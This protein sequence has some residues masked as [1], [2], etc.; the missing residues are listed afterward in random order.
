MKDQLSQIDRL[1]SSNAPGQDS[2]M[3]L[4]AEEYQQ[5]TSITGKE[6]I[7]I[8]L[9]SR[10]VFSEELR[11]FISN[12]DVPVGSFPHRLGKRQAEL[13]VYSG[14]EN[15]ELNKQVI[16]DEFIILTSFCP[17]F[18][19]VCTSAPRSQIYLFNSRSTLMIKN[20]LL[21]EGVCFLDT[22]QDCMSFA[23]LTLKGL[24]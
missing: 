7:V 20:G 12:I 22:N 3:I 1:M 15:I 10:D 4:T 5:L 14:S 23:V 13:R 19:A 16:Q 6:E 17:A 21:I 18:F 9:P 24:L 11:V 2:V 8:N